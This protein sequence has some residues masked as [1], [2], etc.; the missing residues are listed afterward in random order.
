MKSGVKIDPTQSDAETKNVLA[1]QDDFG[2]SRS[3][4]CRQVFA[5]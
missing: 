1:T 5:R 2:T 4:A 3:F